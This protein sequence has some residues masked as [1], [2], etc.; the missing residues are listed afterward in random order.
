MQNKMSTYLFYFLI[1]VT[2]SGCGT[3]RPFVQADIRGASPDATATIESVLLDNQ[4]SLEISI[5]R[6]FDTNGKPL[7]DGF[8]E[9]YYRVI[10]KPGAY[11]LI[12][13]CTAY[14]ASASPVVDIKVAPGQRYQAHCDSIEGTNSVRVVVNNV[15]GQNLSNLPKPK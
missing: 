1:L 7:W 12:F 9:G 8:F 3:S 4:S 6:I 14:K 5:S 10:L 13:S 15:T 11:R 2:L